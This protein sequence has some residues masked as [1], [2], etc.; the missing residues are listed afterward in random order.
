[1]FCDPS[2][3]LYFT[4]QKPL[5]HEFE[6]VNALLQKE[7]VDHVNLISEQESF[8]LT[9]LQRI[10]LADS[11]SLTI[12]FKFSSIYLPIEQVKFQHK[13]SLLFIQM[14]SKI[15]YHLK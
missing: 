9:L 3:K 5:L 4:F 1:M 6:R 12:H 14:L 13:F 10:V 7:K 2:N 15:K 8:F 11:I